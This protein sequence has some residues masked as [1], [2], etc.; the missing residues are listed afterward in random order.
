MRIPFLKLLFILSLVFQ[1]TS[2]ITTHHTNYLQPTKNFIPKYKDTV[3]YQ[4]YVLRV[5][6]KLYIQVYSTDDKT[7]ALFNAN[8]GSGSQ[9]SQMMSGGGENND[10]YL[11]TVQPNGCVKLPLIGE[12]NVEGQSLRE[13]K[14]TLEEAIHPVL[15]LNSVDVRM[16][17]RYF[18][19]IGNGKS[20]RFPF[21]REKVNIFQAI[22]MSGDFGFTAD[23]SQIKILR[24]TISGTEIK[25]FDVRSVDIIHSEY[26]YLEPNDIIF[27]QPLKEQFFGVTTFWSAV[28]TVIT[29]YSFGVI[30]YKSFFQKAT[31]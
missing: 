24:E 8:G 4:D 7:N 21:P 19:I 28:S 3:L 11:N 15:K 5:G 16:M 26:Y 13:A 25:V 29:S 6:D 2:C 14:T 12:V 9:S 27:L 20:G 30:I 18:N 23:R 22:A 17:S 1:L 31:P 10:L